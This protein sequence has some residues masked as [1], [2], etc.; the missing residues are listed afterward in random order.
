MQ[1]LNDKTIKQI[2]LFTGKNHLLYEKIKQWK[3]PRAI[4]LRNQDDTCIA[5]LMTRSCLVIIRP[6]GLS[7]MEQMALTHPK[8]QKIFIHYADQTLQSGI[9][10]EDGNA[11]ALI[12]AL[13]SKDVQVIK[14][15]PYNFLEDSYADFTLV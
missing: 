9:P 8:G 1:L 11:E 15:T 5:A 10:W 12:E 2:Y 14:T 3:E 13:R 4:P 7:V 6:G